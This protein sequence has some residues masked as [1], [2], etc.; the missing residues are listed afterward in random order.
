MNKI[1]ST[2]TTLVM[3][4][5]FWTALTVY[6]KVNNKNP[7]LFDLRGLYAEMRGIER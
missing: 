1:G 6:C 7:L 2:A 5:Y 3:A 4:L